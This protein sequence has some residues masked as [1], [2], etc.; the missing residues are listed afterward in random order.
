VSDRHFKVG[1]TGYPVPGGS[2]V[3]ASELGR[4]LA[5]RGHE[6][7]FIAYAPPYRLGRYEENLYFH[8]VEVTHYPLFKYPP[9]T[10]T[11][12]AK[13]A[14]V[15]RQFDLDILHVHYAIPHATAGFLARSI[16]GNPARPALVTTLHGTDIT[17]VG[18][19]K[20][21]YDI[22]C[23]SIRAANA[24]TAIS[25]YL[26]KATLATFPFCTEL[27]VIPNFIDLEAFNPRGGECER[28]HFASPDEVLLV[29]LSN[30]RPV[31]RPVDTVRVLAAVQKERPAKLL[32]I[33]DGPEMTG[34]LAEAQ[35]L[36][37]RDRIHFVGN[38]EDVQPLLAC[39]DVFLLPSEEESFGLAALEAFACG[40]PA[41][42]SDVGGISELVETGVN[43][44]RVAL[45]D[46]EGMAAR[47]L[48]IVQTPESL[49][50][51]RVRARSSAE[52]FD[53]ENIIPMYED[54]YAR[55]L[56]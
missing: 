46:T 51:F 4:L 16:L 41:V 7:H 25:H 48:E 33:G 26:K 13:M 15:S 47:V 18:S 2:G 42:T 50:S 19:E 49:D 17:L 54:L 37:V 20:S 40:V 28:S 35:R 31:K 3:V 21:F 11:L 56:A 43:G 9:Y 27:E 45:G 36:G 14:E 38:Q 12:A 53:A 5:R 34:V 8:E 23:F 24:V 32:L 52:K 29:H 39:C 10:L 55:T 44:F 30:F 1:I 6:V 22:T